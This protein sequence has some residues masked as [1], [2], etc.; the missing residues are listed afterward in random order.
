MSM[1]RLKPTALQCHEL[2]TSSWDLYLSSSST[3]ADSLL[4]LDSEPDENGCSSLS[5][6]AASK[7]RAKQAKRAWGADRLRLQWIIA[8]ICC[9]STQNDESARCLCNHEK[10]R[11]G[12]RTRQQAHFM[13]HQHTAICLHARDIRP[14]ATTST[15]R[16]IPLTI[17]TYVTVSHT[18]DMYQYHLP[19]K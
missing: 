10:R 15:L 8:H 19:G 3:S 14:H 2:A 18:N 13:H 12:I 5:D 1:H 16:S 6:A 17:S 9:I 7:M 11:S 4:A